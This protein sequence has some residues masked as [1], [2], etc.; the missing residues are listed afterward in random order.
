[1]LLQELAATAAQQIRRDRI[2]QQTE[3]VAKYIASS[4]AAA[5]FY[6]DWRTPRME[7]L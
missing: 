2:R 4:P 7:G 3:A 1:M 6:E 5:E